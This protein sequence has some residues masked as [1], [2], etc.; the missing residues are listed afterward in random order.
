[1]LVYGRRIPAFNVPLRLFLR[2][3]VVIAAVAYLHHAVL[4]R[5]LSGGYVPDLTLASV[6]YVAL[7]V[8]GLPAIFAGFL[9]GLV[10]DLFGWGPVG[11][12]A[13][14]GAVAAFAVGR[15]R[16]QVYESSLLA[17]AAFAVAAFI[18]REA[19]SFVLLAIFAGPVS[20]GWHV[21]GRLLLGALITGAACFP[22]LF[23]YWRLIPPPRV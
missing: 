12:N 19:L 3:L 6:V 4:P 9:L 20:F 18:L 14:V 10:S 11:L 7:A 15:L 22:L 16:G 23:V 8:G 1:M 13:F 2:Y 5:F 21:V 17:P